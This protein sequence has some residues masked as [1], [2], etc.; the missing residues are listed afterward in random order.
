MANGDSMPFIHFLCGGLA[1]LHLSHPISSS[2]V[3]N[4][5]NSM[6]IKPWLIAFQKLKTQVVQFPIQ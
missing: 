3:L 5:L 2:R 6:G 4:T 1:E